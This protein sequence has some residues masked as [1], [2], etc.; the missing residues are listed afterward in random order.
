MFDCLWKLFEKHI[1]IQRT[2]DYAIALWNKQKWFSAEKD[3][4]AI[5][6]YLRKIDELGLKHIE[7]LNFPADNKTSFG[8]IVIPK[9]WNVN[10]AVLQILSPVRAEIANYSK[11][12]SHLM[13]YSASTN[14]DG[15]VF[16]VGRENEI[17]VDKVVFGCINP[18]EGH[19]LI[20]ENKIRILISD[21]IRQPEAA[22]KG[23]IHW[24][25]FTINPFY[26][27][28]V[29]G[30]SISQEWGD[31]IRK[32]LAE[33]KEI[34]FRAQVDTTLKDGNLG[35]PTAVIPGKNKEEILLTGHLY[36]MGLADNA[37]GC[38]LGIEI[39]GV[40]SDLIGKGILPKPNRT[41]RL[42][43]SFESRALQAYTYQYPDRKAV[44]A[45][46]LDYVASDNTRT[47]SLFKTPCSNPS[48]VDYLLLS[49]LEKANKLYGSN[50]KICPFWI[51][52]TQLSDPTIGVPT[53]SLTILDDRDYFIHNSLDNPSNICFEATKTIGV[54]AATY[55]YFLANASTKDFYNLGCIASDWLKKS[56][57]TK[58]HLNKIIESLT[59]LA[60]L[61]GES[62]STSCFQELAKDILIHEPKQIEVPVQLRK[63]AESIIPIRHYKGFIGFDDLSSTQ[64]SHYIQQ[65]GHSPDWISP[66]WLN[67]AL[68]FADGERS[69]YQ[70]YQV[71]GGEG[72]ELELEDLLKYIQFLNKTGKLSINST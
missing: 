31:K 54:I 36:E 69:V 35:I 47:I 19:D 64:L 51:N 57:T 20:I 71:L 16:T 68:F 58:F 41:I 1:S 61:S 34:K 27:D 29:T 14:P 46:S 7:K 45:L 26:A 53:P 42:I 56:G 50:Y 15:L 60:E 28:N 30:F 52:D 55:I 17:T 72:L 67:Q 62:V 63:E 18:S 5:Q 33:G 8:G 13:L 9:L 40:I 37:S 39:L 2:K 25:N 65:F 4:K 12:P 48:V 66:I 32:W 11:N 38:G 44:A 23:A 59:T 22:A 21:F 24:N 43:P 70:I 10:S 3:A 49:L 6:W